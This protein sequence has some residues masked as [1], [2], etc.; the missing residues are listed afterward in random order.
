MRIV[1][2]T[3]WLDDGYWLLIVGL[4]VLLFIGFFLA[5]ILFKDREYDV[6]QN[7]V[8]M[9]HDLLWRTYTNDYRIIMEISRAVVQVQSFPPVTYHQIYLHLQSEEAHRVASTIGTFHVYRE[10]DIRSYLD[11]VDALRQSQFRG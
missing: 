2:D 5:K 11:E 9:P 6:P 10:H 8:V 7:V 4:P 3:P 1:Y